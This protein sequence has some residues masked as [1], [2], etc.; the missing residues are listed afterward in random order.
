MKNYKAPKAEKE[1]RVPKLSRCSH[2]EVFSPGEFVRCDTLTSKKFKV[3][4]LG[5]L[6]LCETHSRCHE[7]EK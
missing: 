1:P 4:K 5:L 6:V 7:L 3:K 2:V